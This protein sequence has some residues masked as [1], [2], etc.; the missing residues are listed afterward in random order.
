MTK[1]TMKQVIAIFAVGGV[2]SA[3]AGEDAFIKLD[4]NADGFISAEESIVNESL[5][6]GWSAADA[7]NDGR[8]DAA[9]FS[10]FEVNSDK[11]GQKE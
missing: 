7:N 2:C 5:Y 3:V 8:I 9:E 10:A 6:N 4:S 1:T 11:Q